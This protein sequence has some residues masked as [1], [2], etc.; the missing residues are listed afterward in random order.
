MPVLLGPYLSG[1]DEHRVFAPTIVP[2]EDFSGIHVDLD[3][4]LVEVIRRALV[5]NNQ[6][7]LQAIELRF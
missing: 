5:A 3:I 6:L 7:V 4:D 2:D 1:R